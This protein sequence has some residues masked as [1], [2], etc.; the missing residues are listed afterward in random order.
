MNRKSFFE[1]VRTGA[2]VA[3]GIGGVFGATFAVTSLVAQAQEQAPAVTVPAAPSSPAA[4]APAPA[5]APEASPLTQP[6]RGRPPRPAFKDLDANGDGAISQAE[7]DAFRPVGPPSP[8]F[9][10]GRPPR[11]EQGDDERAAPRG[12]G[13]G[14]R[15]ERYSADDDRYGPPP[16]PNDRFDS[17]PNDGR[18]GPP[19]RGRGGRGG[20][21][22]E[23]RGGG[24]CEHRGGPRDEYGP[25]PGG[26]DDGY[27]RDD[28]PRPPRRPEY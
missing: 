1:S 27:G 24:E 4:D 2:A 19:P 9:D 3:L 8:R 14:P 10:E 7:F 28:R 17:P 5:L 11:G 16:P 21:G 22:Y 13:R 6:E 20:E 18:Y 12:P 23:H 25:T 15:P 26:P